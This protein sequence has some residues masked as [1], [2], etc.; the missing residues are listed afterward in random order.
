[1]DLLS[2]LLPVINSLGILAAIFVFW[3]QGANKAS[4]EVIETYQV[5]V[6]QLKDQVGECNNKI[7]LLTSKIGELTG[8]LKGKDERIAALEALN[9]AKN[10]EMELLFKKLA[11]A[12]D[13]SAGQAQTAKEYMENT[14][15]VL[16]EIYIF[17]KDIS[18][19]SAFSKDELLHQTE[20]LEEKR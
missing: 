15:K 17:M 2:G 12:V 18:A 20:M 7:S 16:G 5:Q 3:R 8:Q 19:N 6:Q 14:A 11:A 4:K 10:P 9:A 1:M 13:S